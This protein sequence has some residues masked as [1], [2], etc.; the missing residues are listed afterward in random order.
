MSWS[1]AHLGIAEDADERAI[2]RAY[3][4]KLKTTRPDEDPE[5]FQRL[6]EAY[7]QALE[8][9][10]W[11]RD[12]GHDD[13]HDGD[14]ASD[15]DAP[16]DPLHSEDDPDSVEWDSIEPRPSQGMPAPPLSRAS[17]RMP[18][19][20]RDHAPDDGDD[21]PPHR[22][23]FDFEAFFEAMEIQIHGTYPSDFER[24]LER[25][26]A[27]SDAGTKRGIRLRLPRFLEQRSTLPAGHVEA[28]IAC[29]D[30]G[31]NDTAT[32]DPEDAGFDLE[33]FFERLEI[34]I[35]R[36]KPD[37]F[38]QW[39]DRHPALYDV[40]LKQAIAADLVDFLDARPTL[41]REHVEALLS[42]FGLDRVS[43]D[44]PFLQERV[45]RILHHITAPAPVKTGDR[46]E[47]GGFPIFWLVI[48]IFMLARCAGG[49][50]G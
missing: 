7:R 19:F 35:H 17:P 47:G 30:I 28:L 46:G 5:G 15:D 11:R 32:L 18:A 10:E 16:V 6:N 50:S 39:L 45:Q 42:F 27:L 48:V 21:R 2:K 25:H 20:T 4:A 33:R 1:H 8:E 40:S 44:D 13:A 26:P 49:S 9:A 29:F 14:V 37:A 43:N 41:P 38:Q 31:R 34:E 36:T 22:P 24:W 3:A 23:S 12:V